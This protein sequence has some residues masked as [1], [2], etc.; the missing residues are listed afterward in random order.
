MLLACLRKRS[1]DR[2]REEKLATL[3]ML[4]KRR[5]APSV[6]LAVE[7]MAQP[8]SPDQV[9]SFSA[10]PPPP[11]RSLLVSTHRRPC[12]RA[13]CRPCLAVS[14]SLVS[15]LVLPVLTGE[16]AVS[17]RLQPLC[18]FSC[19]P[20]PLQSVVVFMCAWV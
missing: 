2:R 4:N 13:W 14:V 10:P 5:G 1:K 7:G 12:L 9:R 11:P 15:C 6:S 16:A 17:I 8:D 3:D 20:A 19:L 18:V